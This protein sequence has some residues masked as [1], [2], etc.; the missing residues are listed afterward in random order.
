MLWFWLAFPQ[1][2]LA[3]PELGKNFLNGL[4]HSR[5]EN[6]GVVVAAVAEPDEVK[7]GSEFHLLLRVTIPEGWHIYAMHLE[8]D[9][10]QLA[11]MVHFTE[12]IFPV[13]GKWIESPPLFEMDGVLQKAVKS[14]K[15][16]AEFSLL[17]KAPAN[18]SAGDKF[19][20]GTVIY[21]ACDNKVCTLPK[22]LPF[23][24][25]VRVRGGG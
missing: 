24:T 7:P 5:S 16:S 10:S 19:I 23:Q 3:D 11:T 25:R 9:L 17:Q 13:S 8:G 20:V 12:N 15:Q 6:L 1:L 18:V 14:H 2:L 4:F 22:E 21:H